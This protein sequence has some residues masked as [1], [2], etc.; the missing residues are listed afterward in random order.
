[1]TEVGEVNEVAASRPL[2]P[3]ATAEGVAI[4]GGGGGAG[5]GAGGSVVLLAKLAYCPPE[6][7]GHGEL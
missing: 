6:C 2:S 7:P 5:G 4:G 3:L 1:M